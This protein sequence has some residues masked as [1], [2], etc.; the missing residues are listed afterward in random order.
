MTNDGRATVPTVGD[1]IELHDPRGRSVVGHIHRTAGDEIV[2]A[3]PANTADN[4]SPARGESLELRWPTRSGVMVRPVTLTDLAGASQLQ[5]WTVI[6]A[7][8]PRFEQ[9]RHEPRVPLDGPVTLAVHIDDEP[10]RD[11]GSNGGADPGANGGAGP[12][13]AVYRLTGDLQDI[14]ASAVRCVMPAGADDVVIVAGARVTAEFTL[15]ATPVRLP[16]VV[17]AAWTSERL[18]VVQVVVMVDPGQ[19][20]SAVVA[21]YVASVTGEHAGSA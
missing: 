10:Q 11:P 18:P 7:G 12:A 1:H 14:S 15:D 17:H 4:T 16:G 19:P 13:P 9:R 3:L 20:D 21:A 8:P 6:P 2:I 5:L